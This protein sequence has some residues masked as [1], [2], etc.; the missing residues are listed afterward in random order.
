MGT[1]VSCSDDDDLAKADALFRPIITDDNIEM[2]LDDNLVPYMNV[3]WDNYT[4]ANQY[5]VSVEPVDASVAP[6]TI[7]TSELSCHF[8]GLEYDKEYFVYISAANTTTGLSSKAYSLTAITPDYPTNLSTIQTTDII[9]IAARVRWTPG[10]YYDRLRV[11]DDDGE[12]VTEVALTEE[13]NAAAQKVV[14]GVFTIQN[15]TF[16]PPFWNGQPHSTQNSL[17]H[18]KK[19]ERHYALFDFR[20]YETS[21]IGIMK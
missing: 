13:D 10:V 9:D 5:T 21:R 8:D 16:L 18:D 1:F 7:T 6:K 17:R 20:V 11:L 3:K 12:V 4:D 2:G 14:Y 15:S 19:S